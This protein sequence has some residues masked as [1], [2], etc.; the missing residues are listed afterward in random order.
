MF[1]VGVTSLESVIVFEREEVE[2]T[3]GVLEMEDVGVAEA[4]QVAVWQSFTRL[5]L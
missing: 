3:E 4:L 1:S 2:V 5:R